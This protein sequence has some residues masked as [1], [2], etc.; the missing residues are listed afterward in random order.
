[1]ISIVT[2]YYN[3]KAE[4][5]RTLKTIEKSEIK[6][7]EFIIVDDGSD[8]RQRIED[9]TREFPFVRLKRIEI[10]E[11]DYINPCIPFNIAF[12]L[13]QG[14]LILIQNPECLHMGDILKHV[15]ENSKY[16]QYLVYS[17]YSL[18]ERAN[19]NLAGVDFNLPMPILMDSIRQAIGGFTTNNCDTSS[20]YDSWFAHPIYRRA[21]FNFM[22][23]LTRKDLYE[24]NGFDERFAYGHAFDDT[25]FVS[26]IEKKKMDIVMVETPF[27]IHQW[28]PPHTYKIP[29]FSEAERRNRLLYET[30]R[31]QPHIKAQ[32]RFMEGNSWRQL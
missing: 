9:F 11:K 15:S 8:W 32:N 17:C 20:R 2:A 28:H 4:L 23:S 29:N 30:L 22:T 26:R 16:N 21:Y 13:A 18:S 6:D 24:L 31:R 3:R 7:F 5:W 14:D 10:K 19:N 27:C 12:S 25:E 1:M